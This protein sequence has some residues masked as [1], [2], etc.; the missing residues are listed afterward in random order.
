[1]RIE[2]PSI[3]ED[4]DQAAFFCSEVY[5]VFNKLIKQA[6]FLFCS[7]PQELQAVLDEGYLFFE[8]DQSKR[9][10]NRNNKAWES[11]LTPHLRISAFNCGLPPQLPPLKPGQG[12]FCPSTHHRLE[13]AALPMQD[14]LR[15]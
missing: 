9:P 10:K 5:M 6:A 4:F 12:S 3:L 7:F 11:F 2:G 8:H 1:M 15:Q 13:D 14:H